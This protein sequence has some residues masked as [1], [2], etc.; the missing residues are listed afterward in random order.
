LDPF[1]L[2][3]TLAPLVLPPGGI[4]L[5][6]LSGLVLRRWHP[7]LGT[8]LAL[9]ATLALLTLS[10]GAL[11]APLLRQLEVHPALRAQD[12]RLA[13]AQAIVVLGGG[14]QSWA[15][16]Y[17][18]DTVSAATLQR[19]RYAAALH[20]RTRLPLAVTGG[21][22]FGRGTAEGELMA[23]VLR[24]ELGAQ[25]RWVET[26]SRN[27]EENAHFTARLLAADA[28][29]RIALVTH[30]VHMPRAREM[31]VD[32]GLEVVAAP[33]GFG[34]GPPAPPHWRD[35]LP[36]ARTFYRSCVA[37]H[38]LLGRAWYRLRKD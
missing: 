28:V 12:A 5:A 17:G 25:V 10:I 34:V 26:R 37:L 24:R 33:T 30:A 36:S 20:R 11:S 23:A 21:E 38:E 13:R 32:Q 31:F 14:R 16:E 6:L 8:G 4:A 27:T 7:R 1:I 9:L 15:P 3:K 2:S 18:G 29:R 19:L 35:W 22:V